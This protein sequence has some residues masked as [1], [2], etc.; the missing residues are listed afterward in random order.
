VV[1][2]VRASARPGVAE[3]AVGALE[4]AIALLER[5]RDA[6][7]VAPAEEARRL[8]PRAA[9]PREVLGMALYRSERYREALRELQTYRRISG[10]L[11][12]NHLIA[13]CYRAIG[14][15]EKAVEAARE[16]LRS[17][18]PEEAR[19][20]AAIV[21]AS[22]L[23]DLGR[24][25]EALSLIRSVPSG[26]RV[27]RPFDLR[28]WYVTGELLERSGRR[29]EAAELFRRV[30]RHDPSAFDAAERLAGLS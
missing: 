29:G 21:G 9:G 20:E 22:A 6:A 23:G 8:A 4:E 13:D 27:V 28:V 17:R 10:R 11:D 16:A 15:P 3:R 30:V 12:Q 2:D 19:A 26:Q 5:G 24:L 1:D 25:Q 7:A 14:A 18:I